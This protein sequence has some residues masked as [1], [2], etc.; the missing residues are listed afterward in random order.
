[1][2]TPGT[3]I[4]GTGPT[5]GS[6]GTTSSGASNGNGNTYRNFMGGRGNG[7]GRGRG[8]WGRGRGSGRGSQGRGRGYGGGTTT[9]IFKGRTE[10]M[11]GHTYQT[12]TE[13]G[14]ATQF[15]KTTEMLGQYI[16]KEMKFSS[17]LKCLYEE[18]EQP[19]LDVKDA[20]ANIGEDETGDEELDKILKSEVIKRFLMQKQALKDNLNNVWSG[21]SG[22]CSE[23]MTA[24]ITASTDYEVN[25]QAP[26]C[27]WLLKRIQQ[28]TL[29]FD[30]T[31][32]RPLSLIDAKEALTLAKQ[33][34]RET[35]VSF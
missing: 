23:A 19:V 15:T 21:I 27:A 2:N 14:K 4:T 7:A 20:I 33:G 34:E 13:S 11:N 1:M 24:K 22:Q 25:K 6:S 29:K 12:A 5:G 26:N 10:G 30:D 3:N 28:V 32:F 18:L 8:G 31:I 17:D 16:E 9:N 35:N